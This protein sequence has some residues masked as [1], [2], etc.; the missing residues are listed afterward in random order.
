MDG[1]LGENADGRFAAGDG[2]TLYLDALMGRPIR[3]TTMSM[4]WEPYGDDRPIL[5]ARQCLVS[6]L[7]TVACER[8]RGTRIFVSDSETEATLTAATLNLQVPATT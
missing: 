1:R 4:S 7:G 6:A 8:W 3:A 2:A 5:R